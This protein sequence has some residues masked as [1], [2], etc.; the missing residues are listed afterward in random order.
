MK[1]SVVP[2]AI[3]VFLYCAAIVAVSAQPYPMLDKVVQKVI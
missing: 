1:R 2:A 3:T